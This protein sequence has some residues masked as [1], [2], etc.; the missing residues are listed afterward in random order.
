M[1]LQG[2]FGATGG[3]GRK[4]AGMHRAASG[5]VSLSNGSEGTSPNQWC[6]GGV[7]WLIAQLIMKNHQTHQSIFWETEMCFSSVVCSDRWRSRV[8]TVDP[9]PTPWK[10]SSNSSLGV[11][12]MLAWCWVWKGGGEGGGATTGRWSR[13][14]GHVSSRTSCGSSSSSEP[15]V[16]AIWKRETSTNPRGGGCGCGS[17]GTS[18]PDFKGKSC[19]PI[20]F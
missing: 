16:A 12:C 8:G 6:I 13:A 20:L 2:R 1:P 9:T 18:S 14:T 3:G 17:G 19:V 10:F 11:T 15:A 7:Y 5:I 4:M